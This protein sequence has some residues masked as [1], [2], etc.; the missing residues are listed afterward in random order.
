MR[1]SPDDTG[2]A[3]GEREGYGAISRDVMEGTS[4]QP[5]MGRG[6]DEH[7]LHRPPRDAWED[8]RS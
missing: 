4:V 3:S 5:S 7:F 2:E 1:T 6:G 8:G